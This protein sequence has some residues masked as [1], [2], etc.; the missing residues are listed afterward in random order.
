MF[1]MFRDVD[2]HMLL[3]HMFDMLRIFNS[4]IYWDTGSAQILWFDLLENEDM[5][6]Q[7]L[8]YTYEL[9]LNQ[10]LQR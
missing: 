7:Q 4:L 8:E 1:E 5:Q 2:E 10:K 9:S 3:A 6:R